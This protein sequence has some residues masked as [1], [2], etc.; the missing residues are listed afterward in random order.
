MKKKSGNISI[1]VIFVLLASSLLGVLSMNYVQQM[2]K[3]A[4]TVQS[5]Y[6]TYYLA[7]AW[8][9][10]GLAQIQHRDIGF[11]YTVNTG[12][13][14]IMDNFL[15]QPNCSITTS[16]SG[17]AALLSQKFWQETESGCIHPYLLSGGDSLVIPLFRDKTSWTVS[18]T[19]DDQKEY[20]NL[21]HLFK[22]TQIDFVS[23]FDGSVTFGILILSG[24]ELY[25]NGI[26]FKKWTL[27]STSLADFATAFETY[28]AGINMQFANEYGSSQLIEKW[29]KMYFMISNSSTAVQS[30]CVKTTSD[31]SLVSP[32]QLPTDTFSL[33]SQA[34]Y[35]GQKVVLDASYVQ[36][37]PWFLFD[38]YSTY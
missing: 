16:L 17:M 6:K 34:S 33:Q 25:D 29:Y 7:K 37:V 27:N 4:A 31:T 8:V 36:P 26:F 1:L 14:I 20:E 32:G 18:K 28:M 21:A 12:D 10:L 35:G 5:Y 2:M 3:Q 11:E 19:F 38:S 24:Q 15:C 30:F 9:E 13:A 23:E 22:D